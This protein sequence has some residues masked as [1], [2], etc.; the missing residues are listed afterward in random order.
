MHILIADDHTLFRKGL[1]KLL[2]EY[3]PGS[4]VYYEAPDG[5]SALR[6]LSAN[7]CI[8]LI[9]L[10]IQMPGL[11]GI[12]VLN[13]LR[14]LKIQVP[15]IVL[16]HFD[17]PR[18]IDYVLT[19]GVAACFLKSCEMGQLNRVIRKIEREKRSQQNRMIDPE[20]N[21]KVNLLL[22]PRERQLLILLNE[23]KS[24]KQIAK[25]LNLKVRTIESYRKALMKKT[26]CKNVA[27]V[28]RLGFQTGILN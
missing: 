24:T 4:H 16:S 8:D 18:L 5:I 21:S 2:I 17:E 27:D 28:I 9:L 23:G 7:P 14:S 25:H 26:H 22:S 13:E 11:N 3:N 15:I 1:I 12:E 6:V 19:R 10:D 20:K